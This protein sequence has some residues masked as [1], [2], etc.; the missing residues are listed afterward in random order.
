MV[1]YLDKFCMKPF[2]LTKWLDSSNPTFHKLT[3]K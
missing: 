1:E 2:L 3:N